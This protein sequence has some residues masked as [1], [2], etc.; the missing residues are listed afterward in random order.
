MAE[1]IREGKIYVLSLVYKAPEDSPYTDLYWACSDKNNQRVIEYI[2]QKNGDYVCTHEMHAP[3]QMN[4]PI[5]CTP[6]RTLFQNT[7]VPYA[8]FSVWTA[9]SNNL[10]LDPLSFNLF[11]TITNNVINISYNI[12][13]DKAVLLEIYDINGKLVS[14]EK[15]FARAKESK[16]INVGQLIPGT[17][18]AKITTSEGSISKPFNVI[19]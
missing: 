3:W 7:P 1:K 17:Y 11:P 6:Q 12:K 14:T 13:T 8:R 5:D 19:R 4:G 16:V 9:S 2:G 15:Y 10:Q 18:I